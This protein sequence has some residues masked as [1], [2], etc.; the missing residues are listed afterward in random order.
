MSWTRVIFD[1]LVV[2]LFIF[3]ATN[4]TLTNILN[5]IGFGSNAN[6]TTS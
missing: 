5:D 2:G 6:N 4:G 1:L 3:M